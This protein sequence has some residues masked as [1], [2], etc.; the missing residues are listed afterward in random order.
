LA[1]ITVLTPVVEPTEKI[2]KHEKEQ[3][4]EL[5]SCV[6]WFNM[7]VN[8]SPPASY[9]IQLAPLLIL[10]SLLFLLALASPAAMAGVVPQIYL[11]V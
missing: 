3:K 9:S 2:E 1:S 11:S 7:C 8:L 5:V 6:C 4:L 10:A